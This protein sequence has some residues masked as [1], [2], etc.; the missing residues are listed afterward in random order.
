METSDAILVER[1]LDGDRAAFEALVRRHQGTVFGLAMRWTGDPD[2]AADLAQE[3]FVKAYTKLHTFKPGYSFRNWLLT[4][5]S[6]GGK[7]RIRSMQRRQR[8][9][10]SY[11]ELHP[12]V[13]EE[14]GADRLELE[15]ALAGIPPQQRVPLVLKYVEGLSYDEI[16]NVLGIRV[17]AAKMRVKRGREELLRQLRSETASGGSR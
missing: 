9:H 10:H 15:Q 1:C 17:S 12:C 3:V 7:N 6:N 14:S 16:A 2:E 8:V 4:I 13:G 5:C 11:T